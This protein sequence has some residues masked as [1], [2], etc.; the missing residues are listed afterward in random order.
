MIKL[1][2]SD[3]DGT[4]VSDGTFDLNPEMYDIIRQLKNKNIAFAAASGRQYASLRR[5]FAPV[6]SEIYYI[7]DNGGFVRGSNGEILMKQTMGR[8]LIASIVEDILKIKDAEPMLCGRDYA[9]VREGADELFRWMRDSYHYDIKQVPD[10]F[11]IDD[12]I[13]KISIYHPT[14]AEGHVKEWFF[15][16][17]KDSALLVPAGVNWVDCMRYDVG[18]EGGLSFLMKH[19]GVTSEEVMVFGDNINDIG[20]LQCAKESYAVGSAREEVKRTAKYIADTMQ[21][22]GVIKVIKE[23]LLA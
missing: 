22:Q 10:V 18:K 21:N 9:Y 13:V 7:P 3:V 4:L 1:V 23:K 12:D 8:E 14:D 20:M 17:W 2:A 11:S 5:L 16:K 6:A 19:L 15:D